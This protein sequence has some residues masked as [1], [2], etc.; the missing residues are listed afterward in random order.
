MTAGEFMDYLST[1]GRLAD[2][3]DQ[4]DDFDAL[5]DGVKLLVARML[6]E[7]GEVEPIAGRTLGEVLAVRARAPAAPTARRLHVLAG[8]RR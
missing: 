6:D 5:L 2:L 8:G 3:R 4:V 1:G 7:I